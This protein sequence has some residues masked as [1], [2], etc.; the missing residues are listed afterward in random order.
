MGPIAY[1]NHQ[2]ERKAQRSPSLRLRFGRRS[3]PGLIPLQVYYYLVK[4][5]N[6]YLYNKHSTNTIVYL[7]GCLVALLM[8]RILCKY[9]TKYGSLLLHNTTRIIL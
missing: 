6:H 3:D 1:P 4:A 7:I 5:F 8:L 2:V 9:N